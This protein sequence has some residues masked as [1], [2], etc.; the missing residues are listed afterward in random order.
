MYTR[1]AVYFVPAGSWGDAGAA[2]LGWDNR[3]GAYVD[4][5]DPFQVEVTQRP[6]KYGFH[7]TIMARFRLNQTSSVE[8]LCAALDEFTLHHKAIPL[9]S[10]ELSRLGRFYAFTAPNEQ[11]AL[12]GLAGQAVMRLDEHRAPLTDAELARRRASKLSPEQDALLVR[13]GYPY[14]MEA[15]RF[16]LTLTAPISESDSIRERMHAHFKAVMARGMTLDRLSIVGERQD[17]QFEEVF[18]AELRG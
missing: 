9:R 2:W 6:R 4:Q 12:H 13:W 3:T 5:I 8:D 7:A 17:G 15:F 18:S 14:V 10:L 11:T 1:Y 16:H